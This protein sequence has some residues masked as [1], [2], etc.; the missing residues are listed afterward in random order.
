MTEKET[1]QG[2]ADEARKTARAAREFAALLDDY[3]KHVTQPGWR[4]QRER[5][6]RPAMATALAAGRLARPASAPPWAWPA[7]W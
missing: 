3:A 5:H 4:Q 2:A 1:L 7:P 6:R